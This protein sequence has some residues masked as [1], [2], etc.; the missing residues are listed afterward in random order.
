MK[1]TFILPTIE[2]SGG[3]K[4]VFEYAN[5]LQEKGHDVT[6]IYPFLFIDME[7]KRF[8]IKKLIAIAYRIF[9]NLKHKNQADWFDLKAKLTMVPT[10]NEKNIPDADIIVATWWETV[11]YVKKYPKN[12]GEKFYLIQHYETWGGP[13]EKVEKTYNMGLHNIVI[14][15]WLEKK[16]R[17]IGA[18]VEILIPNGINTD[19]FYPEQLKRDSEKIRILTPYRKEGWK[20][21]KDGLKA[22]EIIKKEKKNYRLIMFGQKPRKNELPKDVEFH[23]LPVKEELRK[24]YN[25]CDIFIFPSRC[26]GFGLP[27]MEA[28]ACKIPVVTTN[29]GAVL[30]YAIPGETALVSEPYDFENL[31]NHTLEL[32]KDKQKRKRIAENG[33]KHIIQFNWNKSVNHLEKTFKK[34]V[35]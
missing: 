13:K 27:P 19:E 17:N 8:D 32:I 22:L 25:S 12:K 14:S 4:V 31:A 34:Y 33:Y 30:D 29:V 35:K 18:K 24:L 26:E 1:I 23:F 10:L 21:I 20:G 5:R 6:V 16:L 15:N 2:L 9:R 3:V 7:A 11:Y 28:M